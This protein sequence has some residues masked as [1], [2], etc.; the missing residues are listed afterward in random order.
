[1]INTLRTPRCPAQ[2]LPGIESDP[3][4]LKDVY[5]IVILTRRISLRLKV[6]ITRVL[7]FLIYQLTI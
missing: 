2:L 4:S 7:S 1:M 3:M 6:P 5:T